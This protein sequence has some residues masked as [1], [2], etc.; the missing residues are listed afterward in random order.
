MQGIE[1]S[2]GRIE[3]K[4]DAVGS[5]FSQHAKDDLVAF[6]EMRL[7]INQLSQEVKL[8]N[9][10]VLRKFATFNGALLLLVFIIVNSDKVLAFFKI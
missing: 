10:N 1:R 8:N 4:L 5:S 2:L 9:T 3:G 6:Q 7:N